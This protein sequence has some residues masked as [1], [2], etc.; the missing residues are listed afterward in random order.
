MKRWIVTCLLVGATTTYAQKKVV[1][2]EEMD[3]G[4]PFS[5]AVAA[6]DFVYLSGQIGNDPGTFDVPDGI[7]AQVRNTM[8]NL[9]T[10]LE[11]AGMDFS[12]VVSTNIYLSDA[13]DFAAM[14][15]IY[16]TYFEDGPPVR[17]TVEG[18]IAIPDALVEISMVAVRPGVERRVIRPSKMKSPELPYSWGIRSGNTLFV[19]GATA[20]NPDTYQPQGG[21]MTSQTRRVLEN[22]GYVLEEAGMDYDDVAHCRVFLDDPRLFQD[23]NEVYRTFFGD[24][25]PTRA[26]VR[27]KLMNPKF[28]AEIQCVAVDDD[29]RRVVGTRRSSSPF[30]PGVLVSDRLFVSGMVGRG[31]DGYAPGDV[32]AQTR[33]TFANILETLKEA[34]MDFDDVA[35]VMVY[36]SDMR[37]FDAMNKVYREVMPSPPPARATIGAP[38]MSTDARVEIVMLGVR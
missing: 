18:D 13:R 20:R 33:Q 26:T 19:A 21:D 9:G 35:D 31:P 16:K 15:A 23:M 28:L 38:L 34:D 4:L 2:L 32:E 12:R 7:E 8:R 5:P 11:A 17:A 1:T 25:P 30:S 14:N 6:G 3:V 27:T 24:S 22:T 36:V 10:V 29:S 37:Y